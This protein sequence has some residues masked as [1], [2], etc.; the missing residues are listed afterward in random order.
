MEAKGGSTS[1]L[2]VLLTD[3]A[4]NAHKLS[5]NPNVA[6]YIGRAPRSVVVLDDFAVSSQHVELK[7]KVAGAGKDAKF[8]LWARSVGRNGTGIKDPGGK[9]AP[10]RRLDDKKAEEVKD[11]GELVV[12]YKRKEAPPDK[13]GRSKSPGPNKAEEDDD[14]EDSRLTFAVRL[15][16]HEAALLAPPDASQASPKALDSSSLETPGLPPVKSNPELDLSNLPDVYDPAAKTGRWRYDAKLGEGGLG[17]VYR[18]YDITGPRD[19]NGEVTGKP[20]GEVALK[21]LKPRSKD[22]QRDARFVF[23][24]HRESQWSLWYLHNKYMQ[25]SFNKETS[26]LFARYL[27]D[28]SGFS[29]FGPDGFDKKRRAYEAPDFDW[30]KNGP[31]IPSRPYVVMEL[32]KGEA[33][34][35]VID[36]EW[37]RSGKKAPPVLSVAEKREVVLQAARAL[38]YLE[39]FG[40]I[41]RDFRGCNMHLVSREGDQGGAQL[42]VLDLGVMICAEDGQELNS[43]EAVQAFRRRGETEEKRRRYDWLPWEVRKGADGTGPAVNFSNPRHSFDMFSL[44]VLILHMLIGRT[45]TRDFLDSLKHN[46]KSRVDSAP[47]GLDPEMLVNMMQDDPEKRPHPREVVAALTAAPMHGRS[48]SRSEEVGGEAAAKRARTVQAGVQVPLVPSPPSS[49]RSSSK[50]NHEPAES[51]WF[52]LTLDASKMPASLLA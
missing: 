40:L 3:A 23:E 25:C 37:Y 8:T 16:T 32:V 52:F 14:G 22:P 35:V 5:L 47:I 38:E 7:V 13:R 28:H 48:R 44:G 21:V 15:H 18:A 41:H 39:P 9:D 34:H 36:R 19:A 1:K 49:L 26:N 17:V 11:G 27:E 51:K 43:N 42:K 20:H 12:P 45:Q 2:L 24:M 6:H 31:K 50:E 30:E 4:G 33:L 29:E 10:L 46:E